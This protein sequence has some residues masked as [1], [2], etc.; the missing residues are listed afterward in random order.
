MYQIE[1]GHQVLPIY[2]DPLGT[3]MQPSKESD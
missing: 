2:I 3:M 1:T